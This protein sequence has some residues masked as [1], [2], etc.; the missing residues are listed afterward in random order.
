M[1]GT[2]SPDYRQLLENLGD[3]F[4][5][6]DL[7]GHIQRYNANYREMLGYSDDELAGLSCREITP[8]HWH[9]LEDE[10]IQSQVL[11]RGYSNVY[12]K[13][14]R[15]KDGTVF[16]VELRALLSRDE[17]GQPTGMWAIVRD[18]SDRK[19]AEREL[20]DALRFFRAVIA[21]LQDGFSLIDP[22]GIHLDVNEAL[23][24][25]TGFAREE[26]IGTGPP[27]P[28]WPP[29]C[30]EEIGRAL[31]QTLERQPREFELT[32]MRKSGERFPV[33]VT[34]SALLDEAGEISAYPST[35]KDISE[36]K[37]VEAALHE[38]TR[39]LE[40]YFTHAEDLLLITDTD[41]CIRRLNPQWEKTLG[42]R[43]DELVAHHFLDLVHP[44][45][46]AATLE[47]AATLDATGSV[48]QFRNRCRHKDG[49]Y[50][51]FEWTG[52]ARESELIIATARDVTARLQTEQA[53]LQAAAVFENTR[54]GV[55][56]TDAE[57]RIVN[58]NRA[59]TELTGYTK[60]DALGKTH[61][62]LKSGRHGAKFYAAMWKALDKSGHWQGEI[63][64]R[65]KSGELF[66]ELLTINAIRDANGVR[67]GYVGIFSDIS[68]LK[69]DQARLERL[70]HH[71]PLT[72][73]INRRLL[74]DRIEHAL[75]GV[76]RIGETGALLLIDLDHFKDVN[77]RLGHAAGDDLLQQVARR[78]THR[79]RKSD[80]FARLGGDEFAV[81]LEPPMS[82]P[83]AAF[84]AQELLD[85][86]S[87]E[88]ALR[89]GDVVDIGASIGVAL[90]PEHGRSVADVMHHADVAL[91][92][93][94]REGRNVF[95]FF[96]E[97]LTLQAREQGQMEQRLREALQSDRFALH[98][99]PQL[100]VGSN[101]I[102]GVEAL[103]RW[104][105]PVDGLILPG[106]FLALSEKTRLIV[107]LGDWVL[108]T[109]CRQVQ[110]WAREGLPPMPLAVNLSGLQAARSDTASRILEILTE[111]G[112][113]PQLLELE[114]AEGTLNE[115][116]SGE[117]EL[118]VRVRNLGIRLALDD[119]GTGCS[120][121]SR[122]Q[123][124]PISTLK[125]DRRFIAGLPID[126]AAVQITKS[127]IAL[128]REFGFRT[129]AEGVETQAQLDFLAR[130]GCDAWQ[131]YLFS[132]PLPAEEFA[133]RYRGNS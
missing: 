24:R 98:Y 89:S 17:A 119:F 39:E 94:K 68:S 125:I 48:Y 104:L 72:G 110:A 51:C 44:D 96:S 117:C 21:S 45:D 29:E 3:A 11:T 53:L 114:I 102:I 106:Q 100:E 7:S 83:I 116:P 26:L 61:R 1:T 101:R 33:I 5:A 79:L 92:Q 34:P 81:M 15:R 37:R 88:I 28:Y 69:A 19:R 127:I 77:D 9:A 55:A 16:P 80:T 31:R 41:G 73:L 86:L 90:F 35:I 128:A 2:E 123:R 115:D 52:T 38:R 42:Y 82:A 87:G 57:E 58:V 99:Q 66:P 65:R 113:A 129:V 107:P 54:D 108:R 47:A 74:L 111:T 43:L 133:E 25:M 93:A 13:E 18:I 36:R 84:I 97:E 75:Q 32:F 8:G 85:A 59:F 124:Y 64:N 76:E 50:R 23:C 118:F 71:D 63:W 12:Q 27:H 121:L 62:L 49:S 131:G 112:L 105:D 22:H 122:L 95:R 109:A 67:T 10:I 30:Y 20:N 60:Q 14:Y 40:H 46:V 132:P 91:Y 103:V 120:S 130:H 4:V 126:P 78:F 6:T 70:A 56:I